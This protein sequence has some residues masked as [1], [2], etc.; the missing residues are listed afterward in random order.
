MGPMP[1]RL[2]S[3]IADRSAFAA[4]VADSLERV[5]RDVAMYGSSEIIFP[6]IAR[7]P[8]DMKAASTDWLVGRLGYLEHA[9]APEHGHWQGSEYARSPAADRLV[10]D[11][12]AELRERGFFN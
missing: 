6:A 2:R 7:P 12:V 10:E 1:R 9:R 3:R 11:L 5:G 4:D 8:A